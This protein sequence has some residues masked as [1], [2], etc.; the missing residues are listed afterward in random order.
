MVVLFVPAR[1]LGQL[2]LVFTNHSD[3]WDTNRG[4]SIPVCYRPFPF[5]GS[6]GS[7]QTLNGLFYVNEPEL[8]SPGPSPGL[9]DDNN[10]FIRTNNSDTNLSFEKQDWVML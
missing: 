10:L 8:F 4:A 5:S 3:S 9:R 1:L 7:K 2:R 6:T